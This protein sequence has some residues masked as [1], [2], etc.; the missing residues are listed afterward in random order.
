LD[1]LAKNYKSKIKIHLVIIFHHQLKREEEMKSSGLS[2]EDTLYI[3]M[4]GYWES[5]GK[6]ANPGLPGKW[7][8]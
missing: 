7:P 2:H 4:I 8:L 3:R 6:P 5:R 1:H